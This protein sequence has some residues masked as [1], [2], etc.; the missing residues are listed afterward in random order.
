MSLTDFLCLCYVC[1][2]RD[3]V[4]AK[5]ELA[6]TR[7]RATVAEKDLAENKIRLADV[8]ARLTALEDEARILRPENAK[9]VSIDCILFS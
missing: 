4:E 3:A 2:C 7:K 9:L 8:E 1:V 6:E 5:S